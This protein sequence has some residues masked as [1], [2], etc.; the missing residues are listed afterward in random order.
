MA[1]CSVVWVLSLARD[2]IHAAA[3]LGLCIIGAKA[4]ASCEQRKTRGS[5]PCSCGDDNDRQAGGTGKL[6]KQ[7]AASIERGSTLAKYTKTDARGSNGK[8][9]KPQQ[10]IAR[11]RAYTHYSRQDIRT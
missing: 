2:K 11:T 6:A 9:P 4:I 3:F 7:A 5:G 1:R 8:V 10:E